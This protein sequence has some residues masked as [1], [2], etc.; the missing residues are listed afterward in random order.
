MVLDE[1]LSVV[2]EGVRRVAR[3]VVRRGEEPEV[4]LEVLVER[5]LEFCP[6]EVAGAAAPDAREDWEEDATVGAALL[7]VSVG[8]AVVAL[9]LVVAEVAL[10]AAVPPAS[11]AF[12]AAE[13]NSGDAGTAVAG[14]GD[15]GA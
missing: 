7:V 8:A 13:P 5:V 10:G 15:V 11:P 2:P 4:R 9:T 12:P 3:G 6:G 1:A 14:S